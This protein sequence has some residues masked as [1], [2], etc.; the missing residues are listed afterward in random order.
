MN[1]S[2]SLTSSTFSPDQLISRNSE[3]LLARKITLLSGENRARGAVLGKITIGAIAGAAAAGNA[4]NGALG[5]VALAAAGVP[6]VGKY[7]VICVEAAANGGRFVVE[8]PLGIVIGQYVVAAAAFN[9]QIAFTIADGGNDFAAGD[10]FE[11]TIAA[12]SGKYKLSAAA[13]VDG[14]QVPVACSRR[15]ATPRPPTRRRKS[16]S[17]AGSTRRSSSSVRA[18]R[19]PRSAMVSRPSGSSS[20]PPPTPNG[21][22]APGDQLTMRFLISILVSVVAFIVEPIAKGLGLLR[23]AL[24]EPTYHDKQSIVLRKFRSLSGAGA[25]FRTNRGERR[26]RGESLVGALAFGALVMAL[27]TASIG[28]S[29]WAHATAKGTPHGISS[30]LVA[31]CC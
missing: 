6:Q 11:I 15:I 12:G 18:T 20:N 7:R 5:G 29:A 10:A 31:A 30:V 26:R 14:S 13:A 19:P 9:N 21:V 8:D 28:A 4:G 1:P 25:M 27:A 16:T 17:A 3:D 23:S 2:A 24:D 22:S